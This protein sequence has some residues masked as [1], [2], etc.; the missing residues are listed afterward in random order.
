[1][2]SSQANA[3]AGTHPD[4]HLLDMY[5]AIASGDF[6]TWTIAIQTMHPSEVG[7][8][9]VNIF[10]MTKEWPKP[11]YPLRTVG[12]IVLEQNPANY[13]AEIEQAAFSPSAMVPGI[14]A[15]AEPMLQARM[16]AYPDAQRY[17]L[18]V[19]YQFLP[20]NAATSPVYCPT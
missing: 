6:F 5:D 19:N 20:T 3:L 18:G 8:L 12:R 1:M 10:D 15:S 14:E 16:F 13:F 2:P 4:A 9:A 11:Q 7:K 17:R